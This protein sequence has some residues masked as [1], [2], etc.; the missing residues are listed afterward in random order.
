MSTPR[1]AAAARPAVGE[2]A[3]QPRS[4]EAVLQAGQAR[5]QG[6][7]R[8][9]DVE[10]LFGI[11]WPW[12]KGKKKPPPSPPPSLKTQ[13]EAAEANLLIRLES[14]K[15]AVTNGLRLL[16][17]LDLFNLQLKTFATVAGQAMPHTLEASALIPNLQGE[18]VRVSEDTRESLYA[19]FPMES[20]RPI[21]LFGEFKTHV[22][23]Y[24]ASRSKEVQDGYGAIMRFYDALLVAIQLLDLLH[25]ATLHSQSTF[26]AALKLLKSPM[27]ASPETFT[28]LDPAR[29]DITFTQGTAVNFR[30][31]HRSRRG[32]N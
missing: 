29:G 9:A 2:G 27:E 17:E 25:A 14:L 1:S 6:R 12:G 16:H 7:A 22:Q 23:A 3:L 4:L 5:H 31:A 30:S 24:V 20:L 13:F 11:R 21:D 15:D 26:F 8:E 28:V 18:M 10:G 19:M 32:V